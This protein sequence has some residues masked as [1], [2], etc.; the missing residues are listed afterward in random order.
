[1]KSID[2]IFVGMRLLSQKWVEG[3][4]SAAERKWNLSS[5]TQKLEK[6]LVGRLLARG[7]IE[8][9][10]CLILAENYDAL[11]KATDFAVRELQ[12]NR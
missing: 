1:M 3:P 10:Y 8:M 6:S 9:A 4:W 5:R 7:Q 11:N 2:V 12:K